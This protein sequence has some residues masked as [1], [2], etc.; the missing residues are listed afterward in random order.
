MGRRP[1]AAQR[2]PAWLLY[3]FGFGLGLAAPPKALPLQG[4]DT[5]NKALNRLQGLTESR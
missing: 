4:G 3:L 2:R 5:A 1:H